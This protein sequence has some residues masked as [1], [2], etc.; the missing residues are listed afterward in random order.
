MKQTIKQ[1]LMIIAQ[2]V[3][4]LAIFLTLYAFLIWGWAE[5][6]KM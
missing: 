1:I 2:V 6:C 3:A 4:V 5:G